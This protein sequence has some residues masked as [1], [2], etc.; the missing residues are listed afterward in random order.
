MNRRHALATLAALA[1][2]AT[3][4]A[5]NAAE[6]KDDIEIVRRALELHPGLYR[7]AT[8]G[9]VEER[10][11]RLQADFG[12]AATT[13]ARYL[14][15]SRFL[16]N[17]RCGHTYGNFFNQSRPVASALFDR[18]TRL[19][20]HFAWI[21][22][23]MIVTGDPG[24]LGL[25]LG[26]EVLTI[27]DVPASRMLQTLLPYARADGHNDGK[28][29]SL[30]GVSGSDPIEYFDVF[31]GLVFGA[32]AGGMHRL[33]LQPV[34]RP[35]QLVEAPALNLAARRAQRPPPATTGDQPV[36]TWDE[37]PDGIVVLTMPSWALFNSKWDWS[38]WLNDRL[39]GLKGARGLI[40]DLREN[41]GGQDCGDVLLS[42]LID[43]PFVEPGAERRLRFRRTPADLDP[44][45][46]TW[47]QGFRTL[48][49]DAEPLSGGFFRQTGEMADETIVP[50][51]RR[52]KLK[53]TALIGP[54]N[55]SATFQFALKGRRSG[56][57]HLFGETTG[58]N[59]RGI[60]GGCFFFVRLPNSGLEFDLPLIG[61]FPPGSPPDGGL[62][63]DVFAPRVTA[64]VH[65]GRDRVVEAAG[66]WI[67]G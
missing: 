52:L 62:A 28:R 1:A 4:T 44:Y 27:N 67:R 37:R 54:V 10:L 63:P 11:K 45:L 59:Q 20:F 43:K 33:R 31:H 9:E 57:V 21:G 38:A 17:I 34:R 12:A 16:A 55:S 64:D 36:W 60:N 65:A 19:P 40:V 42:R 47:D 66:S 26:A 53:V 14:L 15:L 51:G 35:V 18:P 7:Y 25:P 3:T 61:Y 39:D 49:V 22:G 23:R 56:K 8:A 6:V 13:E 48:G 24:H 30:L 5:L 32:P 41:E 2:T 29:V 58:G 50:Q 46:D